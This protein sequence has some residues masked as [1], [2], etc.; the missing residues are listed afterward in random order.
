MID[1][2]AV[3]I[4]NAIVSAANNEDTIVLDKEE[5]LSA[6]DC[7]LT[8]K[9]LAVYIEELCD[10]DFIKLKYSN[11]NL[12]A[13]S[14]QPKGIAAVERFSK[15]AKVY[16]QVSDEIKLA[17]ITHIP[18]KEFPLSPK[19]LAAIVFCGAFLGGFIAACIMFIIS[20]L[21]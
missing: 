19:R 6:A 21:I 8:E 5:I 20:R 9:E 14:P 3:A 18:V 1:K 15:A 10:N 11:D 7:V 13:F 4:L 12:Y 17:S 16:E 2:N